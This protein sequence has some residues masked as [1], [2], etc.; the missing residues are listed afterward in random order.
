[1]QLQVHDDKVH[2]TSFELKEMKCCPLVKCRRNL[3]SLF[4]ELSQHIGTEI[5]LDSGL[6]SG[7]QD[8]H[9][10]VNVWLKLWELN[11]CTECS[12]IVS[13]CVFAV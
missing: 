12:E 8:R 4:I 1:M 11:F 9:Y 7:G 3:N 13:F 2:F 5:Q 10:A 6:I